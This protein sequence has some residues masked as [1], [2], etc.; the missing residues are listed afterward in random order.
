MTLHFP[1]NI[2]ENKV[3]KGSEGKARERKEK[4]VMK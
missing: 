4:E 3:M 1:K 2:L